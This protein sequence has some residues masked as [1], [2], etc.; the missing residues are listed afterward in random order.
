VE[1]RPDLGGPGSGP[2]EPER[3]RRPIRGRLLRATVFVATLATALVL[4]FVVLVRLSVY[5]YAAW[6]VGN[7]TALAIS[8]LAVVGLLFAY[9][10]ALRLRFQRK[11]GVPRVVRRALMVVVAAYLAYALIYLS[12]SNAKT[13]EIRSAYT[14][15]SPLLRVATGTVLLVDREAVVTDTGRT[16]EDYLAWGLPVNEASLHFTQ[17]DGFVHAV[18]L[19]TRGRPEW[20][21]RALEAYYWA[22]GFRTLRHVGTADHL[23]VSLPVRQH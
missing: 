13:D 4:P 18:D 1:Y 17:G 7:W 9:A 5:F 11:L 2:A 20:R 23:H 15:L 8:A 6:G 21:S 14:V 22:M 3:S 16:R 10:L 19:R 12:G